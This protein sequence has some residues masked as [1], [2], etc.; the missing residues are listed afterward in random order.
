[1]LLIRFSIHSKDINT[2]FKGLQ[3]TFLLI[4]LPL[5]DVP[6]VQPLHNHRNSGAQI[7]FCVSIPDSETTYC[8]KVRL[9]H[10]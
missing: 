8:T 4:P 5:D 10:I 2:A 7:T 6:T 1:M 9:L 3:F